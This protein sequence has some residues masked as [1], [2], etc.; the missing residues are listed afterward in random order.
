[1]LVN[2]FSKDR[3]AEIIG[4][5]NTTLP[6]IPS[7]GQ[8]IQLNVAKQEDSEPKREDLQRIIELMDGFK[9]SKVLGFKLYTYSW[10]INLYCLQ[11]LYLTPGGCNEVFNLV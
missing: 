5:D 11:L 3:G 9:A 10:N 6:L 8:V 7:R 2:S 4:S 1:M